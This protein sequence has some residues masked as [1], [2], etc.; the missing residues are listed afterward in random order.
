MPKTPKV[1]PIQEPKYKL[2]A[3]DP[4]A[5]RIILGIGSERIAVDLF[6]RIT[7]LPP[8]TGDQ[9]A[10]LLP[11]KK[12]KGNSKLPFRDRSVL[13]ED[14]SHWPGTAKGKLLEAGFGKFKAEAGPVGEREPPVDHAHRREA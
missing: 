5:R 7:K 3:R 10:E 14:P 9:P 13:M 2:I 6:S 8:D 4:E 1:V 12:N 11:M